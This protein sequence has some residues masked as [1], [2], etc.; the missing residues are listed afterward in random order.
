[1]RPERSARAGVGVR[2]RAWTR[3]GSCPG[4][5]SG[6]LRGDQKTLSVLL[7]VLLDL[8]GLQAARADVLAAGGAVHQD[9]DLLEVRGEAALGGDHRVAPAV[10]ESGALPACVT[11]LWHGG[12]SSSDRSEAQAGPW[13]TTGSPTLISPPRTTSAL[14]PARWARPRITPGRVSPS[15]WLQGSHSSIPTASTDPTV[16][17]R[18]T[19]A[20][21]SI[22][23][24]VTCR[25]VSPGATSMPP[26]P[27]SASSASA[28]TSVRS[29]PEPGSWSPNLRP[30][31][32]PLPATTFTRSTGSTGSAL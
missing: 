7:N 9:P 1:M 22:P 25:R 15:R 24:V 21:T 31:P 20:L 14:M 30:P 8:A 3:P 28:G 10:A 29:C 18:P 12:E 5:V 11:T 2:P 4:A 16:N 32:T 27:P 6:L 17:R 19:S 13:S 26:P 23:R